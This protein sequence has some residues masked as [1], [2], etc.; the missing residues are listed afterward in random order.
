MVYDYCI[1]LLKI[2]NDL[3]KVILLELYIIF[4]FVSLLCGSE[5]Q[6]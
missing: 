2:N 5:F 6:P 3:N 4:W 1:Q